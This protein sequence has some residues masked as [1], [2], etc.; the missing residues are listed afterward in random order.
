MEN[1][2][3][4]QALGAQ[5]RDGRFS[6]R[7]RL[8][9]LVIASVVP[10]VAFTLARGYLDYHNAVTDAGRKTL[11]LAHS[12]ALS[13]EKQQQARIAVLE[14]LAMSNALRRGDLDV[15]RARADAVVAKQFP[16]SN[17]VLLREDGTQ[18]LNTLLPPGAPLPRRPDIEAT[19]QVFA[20]GS[21]AI[22]NVYLGVA[23]RRYVVS[24]EVPVR[25]PEGSIVYSLSIVPQADAFADAMRRQDL[26]PGWPVAIFDRQGVTVARNLSPER[27]VGGKPGPA[28]LARLLEKQEDVFFN[29]SREGIALVTA[30]SRIETSGWT[31]AIGVPIAELTAPAI[32]AAMRTLFVGG[33][34]L[35][36]GLLLALVVTRQIVAPIATLRRLATPEHRGEILTAPATGLSE[37]DEVLRA[38]QTAELARL[39][40]EQDALERSK[41]L[42]SSNTALASEVDVRHKA[43]QKAHAQLARLSLLHQITRAIGERQDLSSIFQVAVRSLE[44]ELPVDLACLCLHDSTDQTLTVARFG[45]KSGT[46]ALG[47]AMPERA[48]LAIDQ[49][50]LS[51]CVRGELVYEPDLAQLDA[52]FPQRLCR[53]GLRSLV[54]APLQVES[55]VF[56]VLVA[57]RLQPQGFSSGEC[58][59]LR[60]LSEHV[61]LAAHQAQLY[62]ALQQAYHD[63]QQTQQAVMQQ[64]RLRALGQ[65]ASGIA[66]DINN[67]LSPVTL[68][69]QV[70]LEMEPDLSASARESL[71]TIQRAVDDVAHTVARLS[72]FYRQREPQLVLAPVQLNQLV[73]QVID[74][75]RARWSDM[76]Q[77]R[78]TVVALRTELAAAPPPILGVESEIREAL[79]NLIFNAVDAMPNGGTLT[80]RT[81]LMK[82][83]A[84]NRHDQLQVD[85]GDEGAGMDEETR[86]RCMEPFFTTKGERGTGLGLAMVYGVARRHNADVEIDSAVGKG[87]IVTL[88]F[89]V[90]PADQIA[91]PGAR[92]GLAVPPRM[93]L[94]LVDD[95]PLLLKSLRDTLQ[96]DGHVVVSTNGG[97]AGV[98]AF[99]AALAAGESFGAV[100]TDLGMPN[101][102]GRMVA[103]AIKD[104]SAATP[105]IMLT[106]W[107]RR[108]LSGEDIPP[109]VDFVLSKPPKLRELRETLVLCSDAS[110]SGQ[111]RGRG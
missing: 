95:D 10:L 82:S 47:L 34:V 87:T 108:L 68:Y 107:G 5:R 25:N 31:V 94:L 63:L 111:R 32:E 54:L 20:T 51:R 15:F 80:V 27:F 36:L 64:E 81:R 6:L 8:M 99:R 37:A 49:N 53:A 92:P 22:S 2:I 70:L 42:E 91:A 3:P 100:I 71:E 29:T 86:R 14:V 48:R 61:A 103:A 4:D 104:L 41:Q 88:S 67:A 50:G 45:V 98:K 66:H 76:A 106:G 85:V 9:M 90:P 57:A 93:R 77:Q 24:I 16:G 75:T 12:L 19:K 105:V 72:E 69:T 56:G 60:Q 109:H 33:S 97:A 89:P 39:R 18:V 58:E 43:E 21:P 44:D 83:P 38:L 11:E 78:G 73:Q 55:Q 52:P 96:A 79:I 1:V 110:A 102:D 62:E 35:A 59:F 26:P 30:F 17:I 46:L 40:S 23:A 65:M 84:G 101:V 7:A 74:L 13:I 28:L